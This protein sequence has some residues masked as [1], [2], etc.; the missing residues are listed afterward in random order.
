VVNSMLLR[1]TESLTIKAG[2]GCP[3]CPGAGARGSSRIHEALSKEGLILTISVWHRA[4]R[5]HIVVRVTEDQDTQSCPKI[6]AGRNGHAPAHAVVSDEEAFG[7]ARDFLENQFVYLAISPRAGGLSIGVNVNPLVNAPSTAYTAKLTAPSPCAPRALT[8]SAWPPN[9]RQHSGWPARD[10]CGNC[11]ATQ[12]CPI[13][14]CKCAT[15][16]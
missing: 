2:H 9:W 5:A 16:P 7:Y 4:R 13:N 8:R 12:S 10:I 15:W 6:T 14:C 11:P 3:V 1:T